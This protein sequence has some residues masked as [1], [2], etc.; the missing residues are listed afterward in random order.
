[1]Q[2]MEIEH[3]RRSPPLIGVQRRLL[4]IFWVVTYGIF[5]IR[6]RLLVDPLEWLSAKRL[7]AITVGTFCLWLAMSFQDRISDRRL[8]VRVRAA[9]VSS[10]GAATVLLLV[11]S[12]LDGLG[13]Q[14]SGVAHELRWLLNWLGYY[15]A[16]LGLYVGI[17]LSRREPLQPQ[18]APQPAALSSETQEEPVRSNDGQEVIWA[19]RNQQRVRV[20]VAAI[21][22]VEAEGNYVRL[23]STDG[24]SLLRASMA[25]IEERLG[26]ADFVRTHRSAICRTAAIAAIERRPSGAYIALLKS[27]ARIPVGRRVGQ[28]LLEDL[29]PGKPQGL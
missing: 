14:H 7:L 19:Q 4:V 20:P 3:P 11:R 15:L 1:M 5:T 22:R 18:P 13:D 8:S 29:R 17:L 26:K 21:E 24:T 25:Q 9:L 6:G 28:Q 2:A 10:T 12:V 27:G 16:W 23:H